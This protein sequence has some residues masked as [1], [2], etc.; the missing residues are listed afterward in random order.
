[1][2]CLPTMCIF[3]HAQIFTCTCVHL[4]TGCTS[5]HLTI[6]VWGLSTHMSLCGP[7]SLCVNPNTWLLVHV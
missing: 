5:V 6:G 7:V 3:S 2:W 4:C 1:M